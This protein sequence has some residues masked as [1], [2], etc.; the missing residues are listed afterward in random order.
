MKTVAR[1]N[2]LTGD[3]ESIAHLLYAALQDCIDVEQAADLAD[4]D[5]LASK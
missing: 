5:F 3:S 2:Q 4:V 1:V